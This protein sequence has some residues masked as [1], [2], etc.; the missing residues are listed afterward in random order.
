MGGRTTGFVFGLIYALLAY[1]L[2]ALIEFLLPDMGDFVSIGMLIIFPIAV[3]YVTTHFSQPE[4]YESLSYAIFAPIAPLLGWVIIPII[5]TYETAICV[6]MIL[7]I[8]IPLSAIGGLW[9]RYNLLAKGKNK[10]TTLSCIVVLPFIISPIEE[11]IQSPTEYHWV[12]D[13]I[14]INATPQQVWAQL[15]NVPNIQSDELKWTFS[16]AMGIPKPLSAHTPKLAVGE[17][18]N[19]KWERGIEFNDR[20]TEIIPNK[21]LSYDVVVDFESMLNANLD[22]HI[23]LGDEYF[24][25]TRGYYEMEYIDGVT[26]LSIA[27]KYRVTSKVNWYGRLWV[28]FVMDDFHDSILHLIKSRTEPSHNLVATIALTTDKQHSA[29]K[30]YL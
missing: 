17:T 5:L 20:I 6:A 21:R 12:K 29:Q 4:Q 7:P 19:I 22:T 30:Q 11:R 16:H 18:R 2:H 1:F 8:Y 28:N 10:N 25:V 26:H 13:T 15:P 14:T 24:D 23:T 9:A 27:T 3:G